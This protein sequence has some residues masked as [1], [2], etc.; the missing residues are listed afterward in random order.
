MCG[1]GGILSASRNTSRENEARSLLDAL[2]HRGPDDQD[3]YTAPTGRA[4][5]VHARLAIL[6]PSVAGRQPMRRGDYHITFNGE[7]YNFAALRR[8]LSEAGEKFFTGTDTEVLLALYARD[9]PSC[10]SRLRGMFAFGIWNE[11]EGSCFLARDRFGIKPLYYG[12]SPGG[13]LVFASELKALLA[14]GL[15]QK[16][17]DP[18]GLESYLAAGSVAEPLTMLADVRALEAGHWLQWKAGEWE[19]QRYFQINF[20]PAAET[21]DQASGRTRCGLLDSV[22]HHF[23]SDVPVG[24]F[25][26]GGL[27]S[28]ALLAVAK[29]L[30]QDLA[31]FSI[32]VED[33]PQDESSAARRRAKLFGADHHEMLLT[34]ELASH[35]VDDFLDALDQPTIDGFNVYC[36]AK[37]ARDYGYRVV[38]SGLGGDEL[39]GGYPSF[40]R[41]PRLVRLGKS[42][43]TMRCLTGPLA[44]WWEDRTGSG[45]N[46]RMAAYLQ[47]EA[48]AASGLPG[49]PLDF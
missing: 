4:I 17:L 38:L 21:A 32:G 33:L 31:T 9:G 25:L 28:G 6:D 10:L 22:R 11:R 26:S 5:L 27:D 46:A 44:H 14:T 40:L 34:R 18:A 43:G 23:V 49:A 16:R 47:G 2:R 8:E 3:I 7:L 39:F 35:W 41:A 24:I 19:Q 12:F 15:I 48:T 29:E 42:L 13:D 20:E 36:A 45:R 30:G 1:I 37:L